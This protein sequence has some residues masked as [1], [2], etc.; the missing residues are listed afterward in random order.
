MG[1]FFIILG[2]GLVVKVHSYLANCN[3]LFCLFLVMMS[4]HVEERKKGSGGNW[5]KLTKRLEKMSKTDYDKK[6]QD[7]TKGVSRVWTVN[8]C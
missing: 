8:W 2:S 4:C 5:N 3:D 1:S 6:V 7:V